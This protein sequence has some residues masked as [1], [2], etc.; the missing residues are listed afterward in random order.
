[1]SVCMCVTVYECFIQCRQV[2]GLFSIYYIEE[3]EKETADR[4]ELGDLKYI[5]FT[6]YWRRHLIIPSSR[7]SSLPVRFAD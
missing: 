1:M 7:H 5:S 3:G 4:K 6:F 2:K